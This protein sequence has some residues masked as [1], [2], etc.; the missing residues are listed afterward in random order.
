MTNLEW[1]QRKEEARLTAAKSIREALRERPHTMWELA[2][3]LKLPRY[4]IENAM[5]HLRRM[6]ETRSIKGTGREYYYEL[7]EAPRIS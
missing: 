3:K 5:G 1:R 6:K 7:T 4:A 2:V